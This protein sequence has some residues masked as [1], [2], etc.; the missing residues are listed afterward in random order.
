MV[1]NLHS[2][3]ILSRVTTFCFTDEEDAVAVCV[4]DADVC[5][6]YGL[7]VL[8]P[9]DLRPGFALQISH[10]VYYSAQRIIEY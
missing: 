3:F 1:L 8:Q 5:R 6:L 4:A 7:A 10:R 9:V 2:H